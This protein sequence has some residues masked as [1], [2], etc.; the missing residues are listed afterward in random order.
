MK[1][2]AYR[3]ILRLFLPLDQERNRVKDAID[4]C[5]RTNC[6]EVMLFTGLFDSSPSFLSLD[7]INDRVENILKPAIDGLKNA[8]IKPTLNI[9]QTLGHHYFPADAEYR[10]Q[11]PF[12]ERVPQDGSAGGGACPLDE[13]LRKWVAETYKIYA[14]LKAEYIFVDDDFRTMMKGG[15][16]CFCAEH[17]RI[18]GE[19]AGKTVSREELVDAVFSKPESP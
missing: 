17:L 10:K 14:A 11:F 12:R 3:Q 15:L 5:R 18:I 7:E 8:G 13:N 2:P 19:L 16:T 1:T 4:Y 6:H 9:L